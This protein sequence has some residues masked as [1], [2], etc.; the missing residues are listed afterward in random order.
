[1]LYKLLSAIVLI[2][3]VGAFYASPGRS[4]SRRCFDASSTFTTRTGP[5]RMDAITV[6]DEVLAAR[7]DG[8]L[9][10]DTIA[11]DAS[12]S[13][14]EVIEYVSIGT[15]SGRTL[16][17][18][19]NHYL[20]A[21]HGGTMSC[22]SADSLITAENVL[23]GDTVFVAGEGMDA[24]QP[25]TVTTVDIVQR[26]GQYNFW[27]DQADDAH[28]RSLIVDGVAAVSF[29]DDF[30]LINTLGFDVADRMVDP[31]REMARAGISSPTSLT[32]EAPWIGLRAQD[33]IADCV[34]AHMTGCSDEEI[35]LKLEAILMEVQ[36]QHPMEA[37][38]LLQAF[39]ALAAH[40]LRFVPSSV[41]RLVASI[42]SIHVTTLVAHETQLAAVHVCESSE[43]CKRD[44]VINVHK[45]GYMSGPV[46]VLTVTLG[47]AVCVLVLIVA[48]L[49]CVVR[50]ILM[51]STRGAPAVQAEKELAVSTT[52]EAKG[53]DAKAAPDAA[54]RV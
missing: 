28:F 46:Q 17:L 34:E 36:S 40:H 25:A 29:T 43:Q 1:M 21:T 49:A 18:T 5:K 4:M 11:A 47:V 23:V 33:V 42:A 39:E 52:L 20:H 8:S 51:S 19:A 14:T 7:S 15:D 41:R 32:R 48:A 9:V 50:R 45:G 53:D 13:G 30:R 26:A 35:R 37:D 44:M 22:C 6:G 10:W 2:T 27:L 12:H 38:R 16:T 54:N 31:L 24:L 3:D